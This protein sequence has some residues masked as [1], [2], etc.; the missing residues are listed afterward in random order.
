MADSSGVRH[1][2]QGLHILGETTSGK[3]SRDGWHV[4]ANVRNQGAFR[5][6]SASTA[7]S[8]VGS[9]VFAGISRT[10]RAQFTALRHVD[11]QQHAS[12]RTGQRDNEA[13]DQT[14]TPAPELDPKQQT[15]NAVTLHC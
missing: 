12:F 7:V 9:T 6:E 11:A 2:L 5:F 13:L 3:T 8:T 10:Q 14:H 15:G 1:V 4:D